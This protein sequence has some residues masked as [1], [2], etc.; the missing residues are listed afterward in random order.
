MFSRVRLASAAIVCLLASA[1]A[2]FAQQ[3]DSLTRTRPG[4]RPSRGAIGFQLGGSYIATGGDYAKGAQP[5][6]SLAGSY[7][8]VASRRWRWQVSPYFTWN[9][10]G[11]GTAL[12]Q[13]DP[14]FP[15]D[16]VKDAVLTQVV[17]GNGQLQLT[18]GAGAWRWHLGAGPALYRVV[19]Q[20][21]RKVLKDNISE[22]LHK[23]LYLGAT[24]EYGI[25][26]FLHTLNNT[27][28]EWTLACHTAFARDDQRFPAGFNDSPG[29]VELRFG[30]HYYF[31]FKA[32]R[33]T[34]GLPA[35]R[36]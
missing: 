3:P 33:K 9:S 10:Y 13:V 27:S 25:E 4:D 19:V 16:R 14:G 21:H 30:G 36:R 11:T 12:P 26:H 35:R 34:G 20:N 17:G 7:R 24:A 15:A 5:R 8:Y 6:F 32:P 2:A 1:S 18:G 31:D 22:D 28:L 29:L 23:G